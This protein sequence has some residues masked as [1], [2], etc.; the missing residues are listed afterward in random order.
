MFRDSALQL[1]LSVDCIMDW[2]RDVYR[3]S[4]LKQLKA[5]VTGYRSD[6]V[7]VTD[8][9]VPSIRM[10][11][12]NWIPAPPSTVMNGHPDFHMDDVEDVNVANI[13]LSSKFRF[14]TPMEAHCAQLSYLSSSLSVCI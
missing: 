14:P 3:L 7:S 10:Q 9:N 12:S 8:S 4:I 2:A 1:V 6:E 5:I 11:I 13:I